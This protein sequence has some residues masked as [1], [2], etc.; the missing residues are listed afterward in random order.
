MYVD[1][2]N[3]YG[4]GMSQKLPVNGFKRKKVCL[5]LMKTQKNPKKY[6]IFIVIYHS[7]Q[8]EGKLINVQSL[9]AISMIKKICFSHKNSEASIKSWINTK[10]RHRVIQFNQKA[11]LKPHIEMNTEIRTEVKS[12]FEKDLFKLMHDA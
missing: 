11:W 2:N 8:K 10:K 6:L 12:Y 4:W 9:Y 3:L 5:N 7:Y 1:A